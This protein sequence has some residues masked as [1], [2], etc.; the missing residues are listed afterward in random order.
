MRPMPLLCALVAVSFPALA[1]DDKRAQKP[2]DPEIAA[3]VVTANQ[4]DID[5]GKLAQSK[6]TNPEVKKFAERMVED[7]TSV[8]AKASAL[9]QKLNLTPEESETSRSL[10]KGAEQTMTRLQSLEGAEFDRAYVDNEVAYHQAVIGVMNKQLVPSAKNA[11]LKKLLVQSGPAFTAHL[12][13]A[14][15]LQK[16]LGSA[17]GTGGS[18]APGAKHH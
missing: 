8:N 5:A 6:S 18:E 3:I 10:K 2:T 7:H 12:K 16:A 9:A 17:Q 1:S 4:I 15:Q 14:Q 11:E 13:H